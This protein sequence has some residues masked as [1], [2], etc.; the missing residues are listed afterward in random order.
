MDEFI[1]REKIKLLL[2]LYEKEIDPF[3]RSRFK[4]LLIAEE[5][6]IG[7]NSET[8]NVIETRIA[9][10]TALVKRQE[11]LIASMEH[12]GLDT[13]SACALLKAFNLTL[14]RFEDC[15]RLILTFLDQYIDLP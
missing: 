14:H 3:V 12:M 13:A 15:R 2:H 7:R 5:D 8:L 4:R 1:A 9:K 11:I 6:Q 10:G